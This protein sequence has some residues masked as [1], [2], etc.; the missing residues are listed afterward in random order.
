MNGVLRAHS[1]L[2]WVKALI[3]LT[4]FVETPESLPRLVFNRDQPAWSADSAAA[5][6]SASPRNTVLF[7]PGMRTV[8][9]V[10]P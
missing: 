3:M 8:V 5:L 6:K 7:S 9:P 4:V 10:L 2:L 1:P